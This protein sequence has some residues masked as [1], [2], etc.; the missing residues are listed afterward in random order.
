VQ[1]YLDQSG[2]I[3]RLL[4]QALDGGS[5]REPVPGS[6]AGQTRALAA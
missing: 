6:P 4:L 2:R 5:R 1:A 3:T